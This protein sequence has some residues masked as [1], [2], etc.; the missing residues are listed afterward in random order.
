MR[1]GQLGSNFAKFADRCDWYPELGARISWLRAGYLAL[2]AMEG[3]RIVLW[4]TT[5]T[6]GLLQNEAT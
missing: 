4:P 6:F 2:V 3:Y 5:P 1:M